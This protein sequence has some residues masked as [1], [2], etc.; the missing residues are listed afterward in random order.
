[1]QKGARSIGGFVSAIALLM[2]SPVALAQ[3]LVGL[4][5]HG[6]ASL[7]TSTKGAFASWGN[8]WTVG[9]AVSRPLTSSIDLLFGL[10][11]SRFPYRGDHLD[12][13]FPAVDGL[14]WATDGQSSTVTAASVLVLIK[15]SA[16]F[17]HPFLTAGGGVYNLIIG[18]IG[19]STWIGPTPRNVVQ[20]VYHG[21]GTSALNGFVEAGCGASV[22]VRREVSIKLESRFIQAIDGKINYVPLFLTVRADL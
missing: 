16:F 12:L 9:G 20:T 6:G 1:M 21:S 15:S 3:G 13:A 11:Y 7:N 22:E 8:G 19:V 5:V 17:I 2:I 4:E 10:D 14:H 18:R